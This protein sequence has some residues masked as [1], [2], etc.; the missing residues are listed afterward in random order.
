MISIQNLEPILP[1]SSAI[2]FFIHGEWNKTINQS[3]ARKTH[4]LK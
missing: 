1:E 2:E 4:E 3:E